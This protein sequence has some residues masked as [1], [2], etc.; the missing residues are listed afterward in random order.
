MASSPK[1][2]GDF[3]MFFLDLMIMGMLVKPCFQQ[4]RVRQSFFSSPAEALGVTWH[5]WPA[6]EDKALR[7][8]N[9]SAVFRTLYRQG[10]ERCKTFPSCAYT[11]RV[12]NPCDKSTI[13]TASA[14]GI[15]PEPPKWIGPR[16]KWQAA[17]RSGFLSADIL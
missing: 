1:R 5:F 6:A 12:E 4:P 2:V 7:G 10:G 15:H 8:R 17:C 11:W 14:F 16:P 13:R 9:L 3:D